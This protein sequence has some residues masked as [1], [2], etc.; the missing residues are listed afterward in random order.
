[1]RILDDALL[2]QTA[3]GLAGTARD[4]AQQLDALSQQLT[5]LQA[6]TAAGHKL[7]QAMC[8]AAKSLNIAVN[9]QFGQLDYSQIQVVSAPSPVTRPPGPKISASPIATAPAC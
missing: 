8:Q 1:M 2:A 6:Q 3:G 5:A 9:P 4:M 7:S